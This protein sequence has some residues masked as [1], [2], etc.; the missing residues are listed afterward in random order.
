MTPEEIE[1]QIWARLRTVFDPEIPVNV[2]DLGLIYG[3]EVQ[4]ST[5]S[6]RMTLTS[7]GC[8]VGDQIQAEIQ[9]K[10]VQVPGV[11]SVDVQFVWDPPWDRNKISDAAKLQLGLL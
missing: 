5:A 10:L 4:G 2:A 6:V 9:A 3:V 11:D 8:P 1:K 7:P